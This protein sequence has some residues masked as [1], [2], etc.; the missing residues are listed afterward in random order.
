[1]DLPIDKKPLL[2]IVMNY[3]NQMVVAKIDNFK[4][5]MK[6]S[7]HIKRGLKSVRKMRNSRVITMDYIQTKKNIDDLFTNGLLRSV[8]DAA[9]TEMGLRLI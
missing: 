3:D 4:D 8:I 6:S 2:T 9:S 5:N 1:M 7:R